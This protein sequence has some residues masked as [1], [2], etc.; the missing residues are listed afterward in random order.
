[1]LDR[2]IELYMACSCYSGCN[3]VKRSNMNNTHYVYR[4]LKPKAQCVVTLLK[5][6]DKII[7]TCRV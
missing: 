4:L 3:Y 5:M 1:M 2:F 7:E 6:G